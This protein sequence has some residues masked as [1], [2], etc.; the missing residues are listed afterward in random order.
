MRAM[1]LIIAG[2]LLVACHR[3][4]VQKEEPSPAIPGAFISPADSALH[5]KNGRYYYGEQLFSGHI[6]DQ[7]KNGVTLT[8]QSYYNGQQQDWQ[9]AYYPDGRL[10]EKRYYHGGEKDSVHT[11]WWPNGQ[12]RFEYH[13]RNGVYHGDFK[14]WY[15]SGQPY[16][17]I[18]YT[19]GTDDAGKGWRENGKVYMSYITRN[20]RRY[21]LINAN[22]CYSVTNEKGELI[23]SVTDSLP[24]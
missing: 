23:K 18:H 10:A 21:G 2:S 14:E 8:D 6:I 12:P 13:F 5:W 19:S 4:P 17:Q 22:L 15:A 7:D 20:N 16:K 11:G 24:R 9:L 3:D 1:L